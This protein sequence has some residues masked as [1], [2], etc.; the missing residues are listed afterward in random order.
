[1][2][3]SPSVQE[4]AQVDRYLEITP[5]SCGWGLPCWEL[6]HMMLNQDLTAGDVAL[7]SMVQNA[8]KCTV[9]SFEHHKTMKKFQKRHLFEAKCLNWWFGELDEQCFRMVC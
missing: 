9:L 4:L 5:E 8:S 2:Y 6:I 7:G 1:M 3:H